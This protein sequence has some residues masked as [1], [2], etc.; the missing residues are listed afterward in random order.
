MENPSVCYQKQNNFKKLH[1]NRKIRIQIAR[2]VKELRKFQTQLFF[3]IL[4]IKKL[5]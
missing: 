3:L 5:L 2:F 1:N 4:T